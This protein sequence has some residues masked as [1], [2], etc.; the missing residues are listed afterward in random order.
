MQIQLLSL[1]RKAT[2]AAVPRFVS[3]TAAR[4]A[5]SGAR[6]LSSLAARSLAARRV[7]A[8]ALSAPRSLWPAQPVRYFAA[9]VHGGY[10]EGRRASTPPNTMIVVVPEMSAYVVERFGKYHKTLTSGLHVLIP[11]VDRIAYVQNLKEEAIPVSNQ[12]AITADNV[13]I[14]IDG[15][16]Y[17]RIVDPFKASYGV[18]NIY[19]AMTQLA[20]TTMRSELGKITLDKTFAGREHLNADIVKSINVA[21]EAWGVTCLRYEIRDINPPVGVR[22]AMDSQ[23]EAERRKRAQILA[24]EGDQ[25]S[26]INVA[27]GQRQSTILQAEGE[28]EAIVVKARAHALAIEQIAEA[29]RKPGGRDAVTL[30][31]AEKYV[32][33]FGN[34][35][36]KGNTMLLP[37]N[38]GD[39]ASMVA[40]A[41]GIFNTVRRRDGDASDV[42]GAGSGA[43]VAGA[44]S[45]SRSAEEQ[46]FEEA[47]RILDEEEQE[48]RIARRR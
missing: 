43:V 8:S 32:A 23:A 18:S 22:A 19:F 34:I 9:T 2:A 28:A 12:M 35:A 41:L 30:E 5:A 25:Q 27:E 1:A 4:P 29:L 16:L 14:N 42:A 37:S 13:T 33:A 45:A 40:Q 24:S 17:I 10:N 31:V 21:S 38:A 39:P 6:S 3:P 11:F 48:E 36:Q 44:A 7:G 15:V 20:Q 46:A 26:E 47:Q